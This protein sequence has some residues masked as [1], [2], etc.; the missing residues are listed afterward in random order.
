MGLNWHAHTHTQSWNK[1]KL[2]VAALLAGSNNC[3]SAG[4][5][6]RS[7]SSSRTHSFFACSISISIVGIVGVARVC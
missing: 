4:T 3:F 1:H 7:T 2:T 5:N 6:Y